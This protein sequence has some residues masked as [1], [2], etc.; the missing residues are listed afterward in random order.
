MGLNENKIAQKKQEKLSLKETIAGHRMLWDRLAVTGGDSKELALRDI[1]ETRA[2]NGD[3]YACQQS[4]ENSTY[5]GLACSICVF[6]WP[7]GSCNANG[8]LW[9][10]W[11]EADDI[12]KRSALAREIRDVPLKQ[13]VKKALI[14]EALDAADA[15][16]QEAKEE[17]NA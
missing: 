1:G 13:L 9:Y 8:G 5:D 15:L 16:I 7:G 12:V 6:D 10:M 2:I 3:C 11:A 4:K 17:V 14:N